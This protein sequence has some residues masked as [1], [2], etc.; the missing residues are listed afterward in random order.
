[1]DDNHRFL[2]TATYTTWA[3]WATWFM[4]NIV[5]IN[6]VLQ[7]VVLCL[8]IVTGIYAVRKSHRNGNP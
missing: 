1:M 5:A 4:G 7:F 6:Q 8:G 2:L 3:A